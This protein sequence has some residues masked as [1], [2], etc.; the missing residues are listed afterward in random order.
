MINNEVDNDQ[1]NQRLAIPNED[2]HRT[3]RLQSFIKHYGREEPVLS[4]G[5]QI[6]RYINKQC[7][8]FSL[9]CCLNS[10]LEKIPLIRCLKDYNIRKNLYGDII[11]GLTVA[12]MH[13]P[14]G[15]DIL[16]L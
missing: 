6:K 14:Q 1:E 7:A 8:S 4:V 12:I 13:I 15:K 16:I 3:P 11:A 9:L 2:I 5:D 10:F